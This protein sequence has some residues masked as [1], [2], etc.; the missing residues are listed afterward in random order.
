MK[1][2]RHAEDVARWR[3]C[4]G[5][6]ACAAICPTKTIRLVDVIDEGIRP[7]V[8]DPLACGNCRACLEVCPARE[9]DHR[10]LLQRPGILR[11]LAAD[12]GPVLE[13]WE[14]HACDPEI[15]RQ[16]ASGGVLT[17]LSAY[18]LERESVH[19][20]L[21]VGM[22]PDDA[23]RNRTFLSRSAEELLA[24]TGSRY[25]PASACDRLDLIADAPGPCLFIGQPSEVTAL[26]KAQRLRPE[27]QRQVALTLSFFCA[28]SPARRGTLRLLES[29]HIAPTEVRE[30]RYRGNGFPGHFAV[31]FGPAR[32]AAPPLTYREAWSFLQAY[33]PFSTHLFPDGLG[34]DADIACGD[35][36]YRDLQPGEPGSSLVVV[37][38]EAGRRFLHRAMAAGCV[39]LTPA[40]PW[41]LRQSQANLLA[42]R[43]AIGGRI[44][45]LR[46][47][48]LPA[49]RLRGFKLL[50]NWWR[51]PL[52]LR[53]R[54]VL[55]TIRRALGRGYR[56]PLDLRA[57]IAREPAAT[58]AVSRS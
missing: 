14:G 31:T 2:I 35:P 19:G 56:I 58:V 57:A 24:R 26:R 13:I 15:R 5:C 16:G 53:A 51:L 25:A 49:P 34:E 8:A 44:F 39:A 11:E 40:E 52:R 47:L 9:N 23:T 12:C 17:A 38:T 21:H 55:G 30:L 20:V 36:W 33:R 32:E 46:L 28:G 6:G 48:G 43:G 4:V 54:S 10:E 1:R 7:L 27:L 22:D 18:A 42:K 29:L 45:A 50:V 3:L 37:R 41:K